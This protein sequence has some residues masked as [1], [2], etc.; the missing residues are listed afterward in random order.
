MRSLLL[1]LFS[2]LLSMYC[3]AAEISLSGNYYGNNLVVVNPGSDNDFCVTGVKVN[4]QVTRD[5][6]R[7]NSFEIDFSL[8][9][10]KIGDAVTVVITHK[11]GCTPTVVNPGVLNMRS[12][13]AFLG[14][15]FDRSG[16][17]TW[18][19]K[20]DPG[21]NPFLV[22]QFRWN[23][24]VKV[25]EVAGSDSVRFNAYQLAVNTH[26]GANQFRVLT[27]DADGN[28]FY[29][30]IVKYNNLRAT[31]VTLV[32]S[33]ITDKINFSG[34]TMYELFDQNGNYISGGVAT[35]V[36]A[37]ELGKGKYFLNYDTKSVS[38]TKK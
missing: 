24:W 18:T 23:K 34:E 13:F 8:L 27:I 22:E 17:F 9:D 10:L 35:E 11:D 26:M 12:D 36:D 16:N 6:I 5:E 28:A 30:K 33:K 25:A 20:G 14:A 21:E 1:I 19:T 3:R 29:S 2:F 7:S 15:K 37:S 32:S 4:G 38:I 31:E